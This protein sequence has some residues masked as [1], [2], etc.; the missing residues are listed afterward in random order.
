MIFAFTHI[1]SQSMY[2]LNGVDMGRPEA[3]TP[4]T[5]V[6]PSYLWHLGHSTQTSGRGID[7]TTGKTSR[8]KRPRASSPQ[9]VFYVTEG[10]FTMYHSSVTQSREKIPLENDNL[11][12]ICSTA[13]GVSAPPNTFNI[14]PS[15][16]ILTSNHQPAFRKQ[17]T[18]TSIQ[19]NPKQSTDHNLPTSYAGFGIYPVSLCWRCFDLLLLCR[20]VYFFVEIAHNAAWRSPHSHILTLRVVL[21][22]RPW[23]SA[24]WFMFWEFVYRSH[25]ISIFFPNQMVADGILSNNNR[26]AKRQSGLFVEHGLNYCVYASW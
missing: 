16:D 8:I 15:T 26:E 24:F 17:H 21:N 20:K 7:A 14:Q 25:R 22:D 2:I 23:F 6:K 3:Y 10:Y 12:T 5:G 1:F 11:G 9:K 13:R 18:I 4:P 19:T